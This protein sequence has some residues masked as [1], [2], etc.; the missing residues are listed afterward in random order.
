MFTSISSATRLATDIAATRRGCVQTHI[1]PSLVYPASTTNCGICVV[2][3][4][5]V[6]PTRINVWF[7][8]SVSVNSFCCCH[9]GRPFRFDRI[10]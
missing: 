7:F 4:E 8:A 1:L 9:T 2:F 10:S 6:S 3:P 5:P